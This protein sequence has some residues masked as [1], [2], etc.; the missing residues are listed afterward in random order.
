ME[1]KLSEHFTYRKLLRF[2]FPSIIM[3]IFTSIYSVVDGFFVSNFAG[4][5]PFAAI[6]LIMPFI[7]ICGAIGFMIGTGGSALVAKT[8]GEG[9]MEEA[10]RLF[11]ML[12]Y[13][14][15]IL[16][17]FFCALGIFFLRPIAEFLGAEGEMT[18][19]CVLY[20][21]IILPAVPAFILQNEF[22]SFLVAAEK[23]GFGLKITVAAGVTN[24]ILDAL[25]VAGLKLGLAGAA[26]ATSVAQLVGG[27]IPLVYF[28]RPNSSCLRLV[29]AGF[30][31][32]AFLKVCANGS[33]EFVT[34][35]SMSVVGMLYNFQLMRIAGEDGVAAYGV[36]MYVS[37][38]FIAVFIGYSISAA[39][40]V[41]FHYGAGNQGELQS[42]VRK[43]LTIIGIIG[44][45]LTALAELLAT[46]LSHIFVGYDSVLLAM[47]RRAFMLYS[48]S[49]LIAG[50]NIFA[51]SF[52][53]ALNNGFIS[54]AVSFM[55]TMVFQLGCVIALPALLPGAFKLDGIWLAIVAAE[56]LAIAVSIMFLAA[57]RKKY[58]Y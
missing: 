19:N 27:I 57:N 12:I 33:S 40:I 23:P 47:T 58:G 10:N 44:V 32:T 56:L 13:V 34:N 41:S 1:I 49:Y 55:R 9:D 24:I 5:T 30:N 2:A 52:F 20:G 46:P 22:Q 38:I 37:F 26:V 3:M 21:R 25:F 45:S 28:M 29:K 16:G 15:M 31:L 8:M 17:A 36:I 42:L 53:T 14:S 18:D 50:F 4:K 39:P 51:S 43:S 11:S 48:I 54:A 35:I 6:N 7:M